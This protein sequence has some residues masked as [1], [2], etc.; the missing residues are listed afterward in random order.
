MGD[1][2]KALIKFSLSLL[3]AGLAF[4][5]ILVYDS[6][7]SGGHRMINKPGDIGHQL[8]G[9]TCIDLDNAMIQDE[10]VH[11]VFV[12]KDLDDVRSAGFI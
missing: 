12:T 10:T 7:L 3:E 4:R 1:S 8:D 2:F 11:P 9:I 6:N 5:M